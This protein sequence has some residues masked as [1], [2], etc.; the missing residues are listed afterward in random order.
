M[1]SIRH[2]SFCI[3]AFDCPLVCLVVTPEFVV[4]CLLMITTIGGNFTRS[5]LSLPLSHSTKVKGG[6]NAI[7]GLSIF[8]QTHP[9]GPLKKPR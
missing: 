7:L 8:F 1:H 4:L 6:K 9:A 5:W 2:L 3:S